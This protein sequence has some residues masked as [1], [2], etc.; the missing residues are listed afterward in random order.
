M[1]TVHV[2]KSS[3][4]LSGILRLKMRLANSILI[5]KCIYYV[6]TVCIINSKNI[7]LNT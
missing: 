7:Y 4:H 3:I 5:E 6:F 2:G 1:R